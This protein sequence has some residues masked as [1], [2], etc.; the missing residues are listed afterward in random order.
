MLN[1][2]SPQSSSEAW[3]TRL[4]DIIVW[5]WSIESYL[6][7]HWKRWNEICHAEE[8]SGKVGYV[9]N[10]CSHSSI[11]P[12]LQPS[13]NTR[14][15]SKEPPFAYAPPSL[16]GMGTSKGRDGILVNIHTTHFVSGYLHWD[17]LYLI[18]FQ[19][20]RR[21]T[22]SKENTGS[23][24]LWRKPMYPFQRRIVSAKMIRLSGHRFTS[25]SF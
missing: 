3:H 13:T 22:R 16:R 24:M 9:F 14:D 1:R 11:A 6:P 19:F 8:A 10:I 25:W 5:L 21:P 7:T 4:I 2:L 20:L 18:T 17:V 23:F 15:Y 12:F